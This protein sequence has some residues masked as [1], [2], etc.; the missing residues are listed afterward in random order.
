MHG[1][2]VITHVWDAI[3]N[4]QLHNGVRHLTLRRGDEPPFL[5]PAWMIE[6]EAASAKIV[7]VPCL[8]V[9]SLVELR[10][11]LDSGLGVWSRNEMARIDLED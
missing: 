1:D 3:Q 10:A 5:V 2:D 6:P 11:F 8:S 4:D 9:A 7:D